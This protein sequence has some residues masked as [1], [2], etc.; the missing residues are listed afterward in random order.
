MAVIPIFIGYDIK[1]HDAYAVCKHTIHK[2]TPNAHVTPLVQD[3]LRHMGLYRRSH[4]IDPGG[5]QRDTADK[6]PFSTDFTFTRFLVPF[7][8]ARH[9]WAMFM[10][11]DMIVRADLNELWAMRDDKYALMCV[12]HM[13][14]V[15]AGE[16][17]MFGRDQPQEAYQRK[18]WSSVMLINC[19]HEAHKNLSIDDVNTKPGSWLHGFRWLDSNPPERLIGELPEAWNWLEGY[20][21]SAID[22]SI[23]HL[24][25]GGPWIPEWQD[26]AFGSEWRQYS[27]EISEAD[28]ERM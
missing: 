7:L 19:G 25:R 11:C 3:G 17:K 28:R 8:M 23:V 15:K 12:K 27:A 22:P 18:N 10:D 24:T 4:Y 1:E 14:K 21:S 16:K 9:G 13:Q 2:H 5:V 26:V 6:R 20:S